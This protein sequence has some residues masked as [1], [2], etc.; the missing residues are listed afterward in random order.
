MN[1]RSCITIA[2]FL[3]M[4]FGARSQ[5]ATIYGAFPQRVDWYTYTAGN[6]AQTHSVINGYTYVQDYLVVAWEEHRV[7]NNP[8]TRIK[9]DWVFDRMPLNTQILY[10]DWNGTGWV[11]KMRYQYEW[12]VTND[13]NAYSTRYTNQLY[14]NMQWVT[15]GGMWT[16]QEFNTQGQVVREINS[17][18]NGTTGLYDPWSRYRYSYDHYGHKVTD[19]IEFYSEE[20]HDWTFGSKNEYFYPQNQDSLM[21]DSVKSYHWVPAGEVWAL[22]WWKPDFRYKYF[23]FPRKLI[24]ETDYWDD[25]GIPTLLHWDTLY[26]HIYEYDEE[27]NMTLNTNEKWKDQHWQNGKWTMILGQKWDITWNDSLP[28][29]RIFTEWVPATDSTDGFWIARTK[30]VFSD[31][32]TTGKPE[33]A[34]LPS[35]IDIYPNPFIDRFRIDLSKPFSD[36]AIIQVLDLNGRILQQTILPPGATSLTLGNPA[37]PSGPLLI[38]IKQPNGNE[39]TIRVV[40]LVK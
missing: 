36:P 10:Q 28:V 31:F 4:S 5:H 39:R 21:A 9:Y 23:R 22:S 25:I 32:F 16:Q 6:W 2:V 3:A 33:T 37:L 20:L 8:V 12:Y 17:F 18:F 38:R 24:T 40:K 30:E 11:D 7:Q 13:Q 27:W 29:E 14:M 15:Q 19:T 26:K 35:K 34:D 1:A